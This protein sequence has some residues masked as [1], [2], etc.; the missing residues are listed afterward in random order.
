LQLDAGITSSVGCPQNADV[1]G[2]ER[3]GPLDAALILQYDAG[4]ID[5]LPG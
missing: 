5:A 1:N 4:I 3:I 2:D